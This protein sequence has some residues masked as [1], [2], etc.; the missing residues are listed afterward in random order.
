[1]PIIV[2]GV[3]RHGRP[4]FLMMA[5]GLFSLLMRWRGRLYRDAPAASCSRWRWAR[6]ASSPCSRAG[7]PPR[8]GASRSRSMACCAR[9]IGL[10]AGGARGRLL[11]DRLHHR[12][13]RGV[14][15]RR[16][17]HPAPD[18][19]AAA[20]RRTGAAQRRPRPRRRHHA[21]G[22]RR[23]PS[24]EP[25]MIPI[26]LATIWAFII[27]FAVF[28]YVVMDGF[29]LGLGILFPLF[30]AKA[31]SRRHHEQRRAG[32]GR[33]RDLAGARRRR[34]DGGVPAGLCGADAGALH[35]DDRDAARP[36]VSRR[37][38]R[39][40]LARRRAS[41]TAGTSP[42]PAARCWRRWRRA[43]RSAPSC[44]ASMSR[45]GTMPAAGGTG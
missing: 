19:R 23:E 14:R 36:G 27:A 26:D 24:R 5:L 25:P 1:M 16:V 33:Q 11:A 18:G 20:S 34:L 45:A 31:R 13:F 41:A 15:R 21:R 44:R 6:P 3:P 39:I 37:R 8:P 12:L 35:A 7:S 10:A 9:P 29:D 43:S 17:L 30:P 4:G 38:L 42:S 28:V 2:L 40:P 32:V 22:R